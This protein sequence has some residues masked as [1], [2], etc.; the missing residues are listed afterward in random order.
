M[1][2]EKYNRRILMILDTMIMEHGGNGV[3]VL[4]LVGGAVVGITVAHVEG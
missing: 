4:T 2:I 3:G 1:R